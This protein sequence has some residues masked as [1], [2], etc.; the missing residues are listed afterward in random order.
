MKKEHNKSRIISYLLCFIAACSVVLGVTFARYKST[1]LGTGKAFA[2]KT[3]LNSTADLSK[4]LKNMKPGQSTAVDIFISNLDAADNKISEV[5]QDYSIAVKTT[6]NLPLE[7]T[8]VPKNNNGKGS[9][10]DPDPSTGGSNLILWEN[11]KMPHSEA[12][13]HVYTLTVK[14]KDTETD[15]KYADEIDKITLSV[16]ARQTQ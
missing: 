10:V 8:L 6:G 4:Q 13:E 5:T 16:D 7:F 2:A 3:A 9:Y 12:A 1:I 14:W 11:G 15:A